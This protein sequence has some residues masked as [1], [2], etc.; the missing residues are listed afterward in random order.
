MVLYSAPVGSAVGAGVAS[1]MPWL[2]FQALLTALITPLLLMVAPVTVSMAPA[3]MLPVVPMNCARKALLFFTWPRKAASSA[4]L[5]SPTAMPVTAAFS[6]T[7]MVTSKS[8]VRPLPLAVQVCASAGMDTSTS[9][10]ASASW[11]A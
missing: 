6:S 11:A 9:S 10:G 2:S 4:V 5:A 3:S 7:A 1:A 8:P